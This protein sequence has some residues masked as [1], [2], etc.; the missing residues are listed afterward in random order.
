ML[1]RAIGRG[2]LTD[3]KDGLG[4]LL[5]GPVALRAAASVAVG[6]F[7]VRGASNVAQMV[8]SDVFLD[9]SKGVVNIREVRKTNGQV[10][11][12]QLAVLG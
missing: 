3:A 7:A 4:S 1:R 2:E 11:V 8:R 12:G 6:C 5:E 9:I 10:G